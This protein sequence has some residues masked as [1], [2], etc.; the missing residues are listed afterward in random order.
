MQLD[1]LAAKE[2]LLD[3]QI[4]AKKP[5]AES[6]KERELQMKNDIA[7]FE[8]ER[9]VVRLARKK[10]ADGLNEF[11]AIEDNE[12]I[13]GRFNMAVRKLDRIDEES[14]VQLSARTHFP[15]T[16]KYVYRAL[17]ALL[18][19]ERAHVPLRRAPLRSLKRPTIN[20]ARRS[21]PRASVHI[22]HRGTRRRRAFRRARIRQQRR[23]PHRRV[24]VSRLQAQRRRRRRRSRRRWR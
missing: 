24:V 1:A 18:G 17:C 6:V 23:E 19:V 10:L 4:E 7:D 5:K 9:D 12:K 11:W 8:A 20:H 22:S 21:R 13:A 15:V 2:K 3:E 14:W 16:V